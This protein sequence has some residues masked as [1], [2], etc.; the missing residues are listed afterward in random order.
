MQRYIDALRTPGPARM[1]AI[2]AIF[3][4]AESQV[5][6]MDGGREVDGAIQKCLAICNDPQAVS[7]AIERLLQLGRL[8][9]NHRDTMNT[10]LT[11]FSLHPATAIARA[12]AEAYVTMYFE[13]WE[14]SNGEATEEFAEFSDTSKWKSHPL[15]R[16]LLASPSQGTLVSA[17]VCRGMV[18]L[19][20]K[21]KVSFASWFRQFVWPFTT[22]VFLYDGDSTTSLLLLDGLVRTGT[23]GGAAV[24]RPLL[25]HLC[26][27]I[28]PSLPLSTSVSQTIAASVAEA[29]VDMHHE[30]GD[31]DTIKTVMDSLVVTAEHIVECQGSPRPFLN[32]AHAV[33]RFNIEKKET[34]CLS[35]RILVILASLAAKCGS[36]DAIAALTLYKVI[37]ANGYLNTS[38]KP[39]VI[40][41]SLHALTTIWLLPIIS[42]GHNA[43]VNSLAM[44]ILRGAVAALRHAECGENVDAENKVHIDQDLPLQTVASSSAQLPFVQV[45]KLAS[46]GSH[47]FFPSNLNSA[48]DVVV[49]VDVM[50]ASLLLE[51][52]RTKTLRDS[53]IIGISNISTASMLPQLHSVLISNLATLLAT[54]SKA[55]R[56]SSYVISMIPVVLQIVA[57]S[58]A[59]GNTHF[60]IDVLYNLLPKLAG[61]AQHA[62]PYVIHALKQTFL[63]L[64]SV[65]EREALEALGLRLLCCTWIESRSSKAYAALVDAMANHHVH[66][67]TDSKIASA[68]AACLV[69]IAVHGGVKAA[70]HAT[71]IVD[72]LP[73]ASGQHD[74]TNPPPPPFI[75]AAGLGAI[76][77]LCESDT[78]DYVKA[79]R[80]VHARVPTLPAHPAPA[81]QWL[82]LLSHG[83]T[84]RDCLDDEMVHGIIEALWSRCDSEKTTEVEVRTQARHLLTNILLKNSD[85]CSTFFVAHDPKEVAGL[86]L[87][88]PDEECFP[89]CEAL[90]AL[91]CTYEQ[92]H[93][94]RKGREYSTNQTRPRAQG[95][96]RLAATVPATL[97]RPYTT[98][99]SDRDEVSLAAILSLWSS[100]TSEAFEST[101]VT[102]DSLPS[103]RPLPAFATPEGSP[104]AMLLASWTRFI[105]RWLFTEPSLPHHH[106]HVYDFILQHGESSTTPWA[107]A[108]LVR[109]SHITSSSI[110]DVVTG[111]LN[112][113]FSRAVASE[114]SSG[115]LA[116]S[117]AVGATLVN[118]AEV[119][120][121]DAATQRL[122]FLVEAYKEKKDVDAVVGLGLAAKDLALSWS[123]A[124]MDA[125]L[126]GLKGALDSIDS[127]QDA[128][129]FGSSWINT[130]SYAAA[131]ALRGVTRAQLQSQALFQDEIKMLYQRAA[132]LLRIGSP[133]WRGAS[134][135][136]FDFYQVSATLVC[137]QTEIVKVIEE[138]FLP[139]LQQS[140]DG[141]II[142]AVAA[143]LGCLFPPLVD[144]P[145]T[146][147]FSDVSKVVHLA[148]RCI[149]EVKFLLEHRAARSRSRAAAKIGAVSGLSSFLLVLP[150]I[151]TYI[152]STEDLNEYELRNEYGLQISFQ[153]QTPKEKLRLI[154]LLTDTVTSDPDPHVKWGAAWPVSWLCWVVRE[155]NAKSEDP[156][157]GA[158]L[159]LV[160]ALGKTSVD[161]FCS[162]RDSL[163]AA[164]LLRTLAALPQIFNLSDEKGWLG[165]C[166]RLCVEENGEYVAVSVHKVSLQRACVVLA[167]GHA[168][169]SAP[170]LR[171]FLLFDVFVQHSNILSAV[172]TSSS[173]EVEAILP[174][175]LMALPE[176]EAVSALALL[177]T[178]ASLW[179]TEVKTNVVRALRALILQ[180]GRSS[181]VKGAVNA[182]LMEL[183]NSVEPSCLSMV[184][185]LKAFAMGNISLNSNVG[186]ESSARFWESV[187]EFVGAVVESR[188]WGCI[189]TEERTALKGGN[190]SRVAWAFIRSAASFRAPESIEL[191]QVPRSWLFR[192]GK[193][194]DDEIPV[195][196]EEEGKAMPVL[197][198]IAVGR[199]LPWLVDLLTAAILHAEKNGGIGEKVITLWMVI[200][201]VAAA[202]TEGELAVQCGSFSTLPVTL[203]TLV[204]STTAHPASELSPD[205]VVLIH[206]LMEALVMVGGEGNEL[207]VACWSA[208][209]PRMSSDSPNLRLQR[210]QLWART[211]R[212]RQV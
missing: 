81:V 109:C 77:S 42:F 28:L 160:E 137:S 33:I 27:T 158:Y 130:V 12:L 170:D 14:I 69:D 174:R 131:D 117:I 86:L 45:V 206:K 41:A 51:A 149:E 135:G 23:V 100:R 198:G 72:C 204:P 93:T 62:V 151:E 134:G 112:L 2:A 108:A 194:D 1:S 175:A 53:D 125:V 95:L 97:L 146:S 127:H 96:G 43:T 31:E 99:S 142:G 119:L 57:S 153:S 186:N 166:R 113:L 24:S 25:L 76:A 116:W 64:A 92:R 40:M 144:D 38:M 124:P 70:D 118:V 133:F 79:W 193:S 107:I 17:A 44:S 35:P 168:A 212:P 182:V 65:Q 7:L 208:L 154:A 122:K 159:S 73:A 55:S 30:V 207:V 78:L 56:L 59:C 114:G 169:H 128:S 98:S 68:Q 90:A 102:A 121:K 196:D 202:L 11:A 63:N 48:T 197:M 34:T 58:V 18:R 163:R 5:N 201:L 171:E 120:G 84:C 20:L 16:L 179:S 75:M 66:G 8:L 110:R 152:K 210:A 74:S 205:A 165:V 29:V 105:R 83:I 54:N 141:A 161:N 140:E 178:S 203:T 136:L 91:A 150:K 87:S 129:L 3:D 143:A 60:A 190:S 162:V 50:L 192:V 46:T 188:G 139:V 132:A 49:T 147:T 184:A 185:G 180:D 13:S 67:N 80:V 209:G 10:L 101:Y 156:P 123:S 148:N 104:Y 138:L 19:G 164:A 9:G 191:L 89:E 126:E 106:R 157:H 145:N 39:G 172:L 82:R 32:A 176:G 173:P 88:E 211:A 183:L 21:A 52:T 37:L 85:L 115:R 111:A 22:F 47:A 167:A 177:V 26:I 6:V 4:A 61:T 155:I 187:A 71:A 181:V 103:T 189:E 195:Y 15:N 199:R 94:T 200:R 36:E